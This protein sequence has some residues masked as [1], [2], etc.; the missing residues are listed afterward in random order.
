[1]VTDIAGSTM[2]FTVTDLAVEDVLRADDA[3]AAG[4]T[5][6]VRQATTAP[7]WTSSEP[8][9]PLEPGHRYLLFLVHSG[10]PGQAAAHF[11]PVGTVAGI[12][13]AQGGAFT[14]AAPDSGDDLPTT[15]TPEQLRG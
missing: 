15:V 2:A 11:C 7:G 8:D 6:V 13:H 12:Y 1:M 9:A 4:S 3:T 5:V 14:R 10:L